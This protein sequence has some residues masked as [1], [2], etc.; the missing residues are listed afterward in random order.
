MDKSFTNKRYSTARS[1]SRRTL[2]FQT[3][4]DENGKPRGPDDFQPRANIKRLV[5]EGAL[6][7]KEEV[8]QFSKKFAVEQ[9]LVQGYIAHLQ[10]LKIQSNI[11]ARGRTEQKNKR[12]QKTVEEYSWLELVQS[13]NI[14]KLLVSELGK[15]LK[16][17]KLSSS[18]TKADKIRKISLHAL[19]VDEGDGKHADDRS[20]D[21]AAEKILDDVS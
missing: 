12:A 15:Y 1:R 9:D 2:S 14:K 17:Y 19:G 16:H 10:D 8:E 3:T 4:T 18:G 11:R 20:L 13:G 21:K 5:S 6:S 7:C